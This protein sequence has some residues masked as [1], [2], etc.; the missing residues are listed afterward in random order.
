MMLF[1]ATNLTLGP[2][3]IAVGLAL[4]MAVAFFGSV[5]IMGLVGTALATVT[6]SPVALFFLLVAIVVVLA[7]MA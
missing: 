2:I 7:V 4:L 5:L 3:A 1:D 6:K